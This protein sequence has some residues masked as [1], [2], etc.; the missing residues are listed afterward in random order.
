MKN[1]GAHV[2]YVFKQNSNVNDIHLNGRV[3]SCDCFP[4]FL[5][6]L[7]VVKGACFTYSKLSYRRQGVKWWLTNMSEYLS[8]YEKVP[9][10]GV[11][12]FS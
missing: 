6:V 4:W 11:Q 2:Q 3:D 8:N 12:S 10:A 7:L 9:I 5:C 1:R